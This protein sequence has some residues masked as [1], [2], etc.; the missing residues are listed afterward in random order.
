MT[1]I[2]IDGID[3]GTNFGW[4]ADDVPQW[5]SPPNRTPS[6]VALV[7]QM[8]GILTGATYG[9]RELGISGTMRAT[10][11]QLLRDAEHQ[12]RDLLHA[13]VSTIQVNDGSTPTRTI[14]GSLR[15]LS[16]NP[17]VPSLSGLATRVQASFLCADP[18][19]EAIEPT[20]RHMA[21]AATR[22]DL[23]LGTAPS[24]PLIE[25]MGSAINP[26]VT[27]RDAGGTAVLTLTFGAT[28]LAATESLLLDCTRGTITKYVAGVASD[29]ISL[30]TAGQI[31][32]PRPFD[33]QDG[34]YA[35]NFWPTIE[36]S[37]GTGRAIYAKR[38]L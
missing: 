3:I 35:L 14:Q 19:W 31:S 8:G 36:T 15:S 2:L 28:T 18:T 32:F 9:P 5:L 22:Y 30:L 13:G 27:Y 12:I 37:T 26:V 29:A 4:Y 23:A 33:P 25:I 38:Y 20:I 16:L 10:T 21:V 1:A 11:V 34:N 24:N 6:I 7:N 17:L